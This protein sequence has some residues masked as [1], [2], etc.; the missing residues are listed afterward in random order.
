MN[1]PEE[2]AKKVKDYVARFATRDA[3]E[4]AE[5]AE[6]EDSDMSDDEDMDDDEDVAAHGLEL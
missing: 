2:Y 5:G 1:A 3:V 4:E 6:P